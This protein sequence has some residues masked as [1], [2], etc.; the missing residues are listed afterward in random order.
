MGSRPP[1]RGNELI[2]GWTQDPKVRFVAAS[3]LV[4]HRVQLEVD[5][6]EPA[7]EVNRQRGSVDARDNAL[8]EPLGQ[9]E[10]K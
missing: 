10:A 1:C 9:P 3:A 4:H 6:V 8:P 7:G 2:A 5:L